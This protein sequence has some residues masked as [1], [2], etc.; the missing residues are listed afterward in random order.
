MLIEIENE[1]YKEQ[2]IFML[3][4]SMFG[5][6]SYSFV[7]QN[8][9]NIERKNLFKLSKF[10]YFYYSKN[11]V[12]TR[13]SILFLFK[14]SNG[15]EDKVII[16]K[17][18]KMY[19]L[20]NVDIDKNYFNGSIF[21]ISLNLTD[22]EIIIYDTFMICGHNKTRISFTDRISDCDCFIHNI[23]SSY[24]IKIV[25]YKDTAFNV[26]SNEE[27]F[28]IPNN[29]PLMNGINYSAFKWKPC[30][31]ISFSLQAKEVEDDMEMYT[32]NFRCLKKFCKIH[33][34]DSNGAEYIKTIKNLEK[35]KNDC[36]VDIN[37]EDNKIKI[38]EVN[39]EKML[40]NNI[41]SIEKIL[42]I[43]KENITLDDI[44]NEQ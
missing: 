12:N 28:M 31:L 19:R 23:I 9:I 34:S 3:N 22:N 18:F 25:E 37:I 43:K 38:I 13:R 20:D 40:P 7:G 41:R 39:T 30:N 6:N 24:E 36:I 32:T 33:G 35:Y 29:F 14:N 21:D 4:N 1:K 26:S 27:L 15:D 44:K 42:I 16:L 11:T 10:E 5:V 17:D 8:F 2:V